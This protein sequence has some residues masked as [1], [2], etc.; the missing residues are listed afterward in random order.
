MEQEHTESGKSPQSR[1]ANSIER[2]KEKNFPPKT[3][4]RS[5]L[6]NDAQ[7]KQINVIR[8]KERGD[9]G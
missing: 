4:G 9:S 8:Q 6:M 5:H 3:R 7:I 1:V 2:S